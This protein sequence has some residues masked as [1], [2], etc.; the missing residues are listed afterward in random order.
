[1][2]EAPLIF[3]LVI[4][5]FARDIPDRSTF[6]N[7]ALARD[8]PGP[9]INPFRMKYPVGIV[10]V[11]ALRSPPVTN[12]VSVAPV[13]STLATFAFVRITSV[14]SNP[15]RFAPGM[16]TPVPRMNPP[17]TTYPVGIVS[18]VDAPPVTP[19]LTTPVNTTRERFAAE[20][21]IFVIIELVNTHPDKS[22]PVNCNP[23][24]SIPE[25]AVKTPRLRTYGPRI[26]PLR[27]I[28]PVGSAAESVPVIAPDVSRV[29]LA[30]TRLAPAIDTPARDTPL[31]SVFERFALTRFTFGPTMC[32]PR[33]KYPAGSVG[34]VI[35]PVPELRPPVIIPVR[36]VP[37]SIAPEISAFVIVAVVRL[38]L[39]RLAP[40][41]DT[42]E[43]SM[44]VRFAF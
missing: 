9:T 11:V 13:K 40:T 2:V 8:T 28:Y 36:V 30:P 19:P 21:S 44:F 26:Y 34:A 39:V 3:A 23:V 29:R 14:R 7:T 25:K 16:E 12:R 24:I 41:R 17:R 32:P 33:T 43:R 15:E 1:M 10:A 42:P 18:A 6:V 22:A 35:P 4:T 38:E 31:R 37:V 5:L 20:I 27:G